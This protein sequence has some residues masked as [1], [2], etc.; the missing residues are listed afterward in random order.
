MYV[1]SSCDVDIDIPGI[2]RE[3]ASR[4]VTDIIASANAVIPDG[5][6]NAGVHGQLTV[7]IP[8]LPVF[9]VPEFNVGSAVG[10]A[11]GSTALGS[12]TLGSS[13]LLPILAA[14]SMG[15]IGS[16]GS[17]SSSLD[18]GSGDITLPGSSTSSISDI[19]LALG[20]T[21]GSS[22]SDEG[23]GSSGS[24]GQGGF[25]SMDLTGSLG[26]FESSIGDLVTGSTGSS[27]SEGGSGSEAGLELGL[28]FILGSAA[29]PFASLAGSVDG[30]SLPGA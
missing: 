14:G 28:Q 24:S 9:E 29:L 19:M 12:V 4:T 13:A 16:G 6:V 22:G 2:D 15:A 10:V 3:W 8:G 23:S 30:G 18:F 5:W 1:G 26:D 27:G 7:T 21:G 20:S 11:V 17:G 25:G